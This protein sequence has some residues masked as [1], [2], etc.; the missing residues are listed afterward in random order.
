[1]IFKLDGE[2]MA[3]PRYIEMPEDG[4]SPVD[5]VIIAMNMKPAMTEK[6]LLGGLGG[7]ELGKAEFEERCEEDATFI[8]GIAFDKQGENVISGSPIGDAYPE[9]RHKH[10]PVGIYSG[11][12]SILYRYDHVKYTE[13]QRLA[14]DIAEVSRAAELAGGQALVFTD[15]P[16][17][18]LTANIA[19]GKTD[20]I[21]KYCN[22][23]PLR[24]ASRDI[25]NRVADFERDY[26]GDTIAESPR[27]RKI[28]EDRGMD[29]SEY[30]KDFGGMNIVREC[31]AQLEGAS[32]FG[33]LSAINSL[34]RSGGGPEG[35]D[36][37]RWNLEAACSNKQ[38]ERDGRTSEAYESLKRAA[39]EVDSDSPD[40]GLD[41]PDSPEA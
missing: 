37:M 34:A 39:R 20:Y 8:Y 27:Y 7:W 35:A 21:R 2:G 29:I 36:N 13:A 24:C 3:R 19:T 30:A 10:D 1:M 32:V 22:I 40:T 25:G 6:A 5:K 9:L 12:E 31:R 14:R 26:A 41:G 18:G 23:E 4:I 17:A 28:F 11:S 15:D 33:K 16:S 38:P